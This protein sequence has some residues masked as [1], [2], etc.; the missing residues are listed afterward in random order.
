LLIHENALIFFYILSFWL[1]QK[2]LDGDCRLAIRIVLI[3][4]SAV[5]IAFGNKINQ[6]GTV[7]IISYCIYAVAIILKNGIKFN[8]LLKVFA[9]LLCYVVAF[10]GISNLCNLYVNNVVDKS[11]NQ[12]VDQE[13]YALPLGWGLYLGANY[14]ESGVWNLE[15]AENYKKYQE[16]D[17]E[18]DAVEYQTRLINERLQIYKDSPLLVFPHFFN[19]LQALWCKPFLPFSYE[20]GNSLNDFVLSGWGGI[21]NKIFICLSY[22]T[23]I[24]LCTIILFSVKSSK[25]TKDI[26][27]P[28]IQFELMIIGITAALILFEVTPKYVSYLQ[29]IL[30]CIALF[31]VKYFCEI[32]DKL[33]KHKLRVK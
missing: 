16:F 4:L 15:D 27:C 25:K 20:Q 22:I 10:F 19:K 2:A 33:C 9:I 8:N 6:G 23:F 7:V 11:S 3:C 18:K 32:S 28:V 1:L 21:I 31:N 13:K 14:E 17:N 12:I 30:F 24:L 26:Y 29:I 5:L